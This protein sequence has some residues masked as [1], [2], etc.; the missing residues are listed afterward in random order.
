MPTLCRSVN[1]LSASQG[2]GDIAPSL[3]LASDT[4]TSRRLPIAG[5]QKGTLR[6]ERPLKK[7]MTGPDGKQ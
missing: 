2:K 1:Q 6:E 4:R 3:Y 5:N 7:D